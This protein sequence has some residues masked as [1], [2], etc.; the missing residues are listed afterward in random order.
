MYSS[1][2]KADCVTTASKNLAL[3]FSKVDC[4]LG[5]GFVQ[6]RAASER[7]VEGHGATVTL[8]AE[9]Y[10]ATTGK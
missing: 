9:V 1:Q 7:V 2:S 3:P 6:E 4:R 5:K 8:I 10:R